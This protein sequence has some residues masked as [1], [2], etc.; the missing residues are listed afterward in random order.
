MGKRKKTTDRVVPALPTVPHRL[1]VTPLAGPSTT[2]ILR[3]KTSI[4]QDGAVRQTRTVI[5]V[6]DEQHSRRPIKL[7]PDTRK[8]DVPVYDAYDGGVEGGLES[9]DEQGR[10]LRESDDPLRQWAEDHLATFLEELLRLEGRGDHRDSMNCVSCRKGA[11]DH[12]CIDCFA[13]GRL[14]CQSCVLRE[15]Q[16]LPFHRIEHW[17]GTA[18]KR[19]SLRELGLRIQLGHWSGADRRCPLPRP[20]AGDDFVI[21]DNSG[22]HQVALDYCNCGQG[23]ADTVQ[24]LRAG[25]FPATTTNPRTAATFTVL[26]RYHLLSFESKCSGFEFY[27]S[28]ARETNNMKHKP[29]KDRYH[30]F[31]RMTREWRQLKMLKRAGRGHDPAGAK[32]T[33]DGSCALLCP[34]CPHPGKNLPPGWESVTQEKQFLYA[35][36]LAI[37]ANFRLKR[38][39]VSSEEKDPGLSKGSA[40]FCDVEEYMTHVRANWHRKQER[41]HCVA[42]DAVDKPDREARGTASSGIGAVDCARHNMKR[43]NAV[44]DL[45]LGER[46]INMDYMFLKSVAGTELMRLFVSYDIVCQWHINIWIR[47]LQYQNDAI[48]LDGR[49]KFLT[50]LIPKFHL[51]AHIEACNLRFSFMLT[52]DVGQTDGE[53]PERGWANANPLAR[54]TKEMGPGSRRD[55][56]NDHFND[57]NHKKII[58][59]GY[60]LRRKTQT[61]VPEMVTTTQALEDLEKSVGEATV[62]E[63]TE[64]AVKWEADP[65]APNPFET[66]CKDD[67]LAKVRSELAAEAAAREAVGKEDDGSVRDDMHVTELLAMG[68][69]LEDQQRILAFD[70]AGTGLHPTDNQRRAMVERTAKLR[71]KIFAWIDV[72]VKF[73]PELVRIRELEDQARARSAGS[74]PIPGVKVSD[75]T[76]WL[77]SAMVAGPGAESRVPSC[78]REIQQHEYRLRVGQGN[79]ALHEVRRMLLVRTHL[80]K[81]K[82]THSR[83]VRANMRS[84]AKITALNDRIR[85]A[86]AQYRAARKALQALGRVLKRHEWERTLQDLKE[87]DVRGLP[88]SRFG[89]PERQ[90]GKKAKKKSRSKRA[91]TERQERPLSWIWIAQESYDPGSTGAMAEGVRIEWAKARAR[92]LRWREEVDLLEEEMRRVLQF[93]RWRAGWWRAQAALQDELVAAFTEDWRMLPELIE[94]GRAG[95][96]VEENSSGGESDDDDNDEGEEAGEEEEAIDKLPQRPVQAAYVDEVLTAASRLPP[97]ASRLPPPASRLPPPTSRLPPPAYGLRPPASSLPSPICLLPPAYRLPHTASHPTASR[98][99]P[100]ASRLLPT[101]YDLLPPASRL[102][103]AYYLPPTASRILPPTLRPPAYGLPPMAS[104]LLSP[105]YRLLPPPTASRIPPHAYSLPPAASRLPPPALCSP[106]WPSVL[107]HTF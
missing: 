61:A 33:K 98:L 52:R 46:Y 38:K 49:G 100:P 105:A 70:V 35:L 82:D 80:Y 5:D 75:L 76:L 91:R 107:L 103:S 83:G 85:R 39:E 59:L 54:S 65:D 77:P 26:H 81:L 58:A 73:F 92:R 69:Q 47:M 63:W 88:R 20:P 57:L 11:P 78:T 1:P 34:A 23:G 24:L 40:F 8:D 55:V 42:H 104:R 72:Q 95:N 7:Y 6:P 31:L 67:H 22:V 15:H 53:A 93:T 2:R 84:N 99:P 86:A 32:G 51:P 9:D 71:R 10:D 74:Q 44:G 106:H 68:L 94:G 50:F 29:N 25:L 56:L 96:G 12:R 62:K 89:D 16:E 43:P 17:N 45:Q 28:L 60:A 48:T 18:F 4:A 90:A 102:P 41:S 21:V 19:K 27:Q 79:E 64:M 87:E 36:F 30:E 66:Q 97:P 13:G 37:D 3:E 14:H 101:A